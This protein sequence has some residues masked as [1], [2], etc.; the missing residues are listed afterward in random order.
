MSKDTVTEDEWRAA[1]A[2]ATKMEHQDPG[3]GW[4]SNLE[5]ASLVGLSRQRMRA[6]LAALDKAGQLETA[7]RTKLDTRGRRYAHPVYRLKKPSKGE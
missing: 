4:K 2:E 3:P 1:L 7:M 6:K 5:L